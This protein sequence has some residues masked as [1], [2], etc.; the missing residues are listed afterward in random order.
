MAT[1]VVTPFLFHNDRLL[2]V[3]PNP[4]GLANLVAFMS[5]CTE[6]CLFDI[7]PKDGIARLID[8]G[9]TCDLSSTDMRI[10]ASE[11]AP[12]TLSVPLRYDGKEEDKLK[13]AKE[14]VSDER[15]M[16]TIVLWHSTAAAAC[17]WSVVGGHGT[18]LVFHVQRSHR[19]IDTRNWLAVIHLS[20]VLDRVSALMWSTGPYHGLHSHFFA[21][22]YDT[23]CIDYQRD[24]AILIYSVVDRTFSKHDTTE[25]AACAF[26]SLALVLRIRGSM[27]EHVLP[28]E[29]CD[30]N[31]T[32]LS[33][34]ESDIAIDK[35][36]AA[37]GKVAVA[38]S[39]VAAVAV[40]WRFLRRGYSCRNMPN[41]SH[42]LTSA[43]TRAKYT[44][45]ASTDSKYIDEETGFNGDRVRMKVG[46]AL[47]DASFPGN[48]VAL[49]RASSADG[50]R[51]LVVKTFGELQACTTNS[52]GS[53]FYAFPSLIHSNEWAKPPER[54]ENQFDEYENHSEREQYVQW[55][56]YLP[57]SGHVVAYGSHSLKT[58][59]WLLD[60]TTL[61]PIFSYNCDALDQVRLVCTLPNDRLL[62]ERSNID[63]FP[64]TTM[65][66]CMFSGTYRTVHLMSDRLA[67]DFL[68]PLP[69][70]SNFLRIR[71]ELVLH[72][73]AELL[74]IGVTHIILSYGPSLTTI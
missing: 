60:I 71:T 65:I 61:R 43:S 37:A 70:C 27:V 59:L 3:N 19:R 24:G 42:V 51:H 56:A 15:P 57:R 8:L 44:G 69:P 26:P 50:R 67:A 10:D 31:V 36:A 13:Y 21:T 52:R 1:V 23:Y 47:H 12:L 49:T 25:S 11:S 29:T 18:S 48:A 4:D 46:V 33:V 17:E 68:V 14:S 22:Y 62:V 38:A 20:S 30:S 58:F 55:A 54:P 34:G 72:S 35:I 41:M 5:G 45:E 9:T 40:D 39:K 64:P 32:G 53:Q 66:L 74:P 6:G 28:F 16:R 7:R 2:H 73:I 63:D